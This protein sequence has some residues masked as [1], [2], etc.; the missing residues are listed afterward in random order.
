MNEKKPE[1]IIVSEMGRDSNWLGT[2]RSLGRKGIPVIKL[3]PKNWYN[4]KYCV[5][6]ISPTMAEKPRE[7]INFLIKLGKKRNCEDVLFPASDNA[8]ILM[9]KNKD[10]LKN[11]FEPVASD[12]DTTEKIVDK[13][14]TYKFAKA[15]SIPVPKTFV[16][17]DINEV[18]HTAKEIRY[19]CLLKPACSHIFGPKFKTKLLKVNS[20]TEL[21][22]KYKHLSSH[23]HKLLVQEEIPGGDDQIYYLGIVCNKN[24]EPLAVFTFRKL[25]QYPPHFGVG[26]FE[27]SVWE[28]RIVDL[29]IRLLKGIKFYGIAGV[30]FKKD[31]RTG[32]F[33]LIEI[34]GRSWT[35]NYLATFCGVNLAYIAYKD[36]IGEKQKPLDNYSCRY[37]LGVKWAH[38][39]ID[40]LSMIK[41]RKEGEI[42]F[43]KWLHSILIG[44]KTFAIL[45]LDDPYPFVS[46]L[47][48]S[49]DFIKN[50]MKNV[51]NL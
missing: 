25:R 16:P 2:A 20:K 19:P 35:G 27:E 43:A 8:L 36:A 45:S 30:E 41:K 3:A 22:K 21:I 4:S 9:S 39:S 23:G 10:I 17:E 6:V 49:I 42:T 46:E 51:K 48:N 47:K 40:F 11:Y 26:S 5:S 38:L 33:E 37:E 44:R 1:A 15:L 50:G 12:W 28:P 34:N 7:F 14:K 24:S 13:S 32:D 18:K 29:G 31:D